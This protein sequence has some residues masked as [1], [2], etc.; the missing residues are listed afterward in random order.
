MLLFTK[1]RM[2]ACVQKQVTYIAALINTT[3]Y[4]ATYIGANTIANKS[5]NYSV[6]V[7]KL[8]NTTHIFSQLPRVV[9]YVHCRLN[10]G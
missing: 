2:Y 6:Q 7:N 3:I 1:V 4:V 10:W 9:G 5:S 8:K